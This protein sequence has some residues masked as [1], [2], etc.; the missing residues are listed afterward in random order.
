MGFGSVEQRPSQF[1]R[2]LEPSRNG[3]FFCGYTALGNESNSDASG[4]RD[5]WHRSGI[6]HKWAS[7]LA[8]MTERLTGIVAPRGITIEGVPG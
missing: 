8:P 4:K 6:A 1:H 7:K 2:D 3:F 5:W